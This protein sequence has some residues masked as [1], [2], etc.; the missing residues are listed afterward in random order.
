MRQSKTWQLRAY[1]RAI[2]VRKQYGN[3]IEKQVWLGSI[4]QGSN[5]CILEG[6]TSC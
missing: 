2:M 4:G 3:N 6:G 1:I 5:N